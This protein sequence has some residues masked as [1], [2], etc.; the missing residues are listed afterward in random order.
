MKK[1]KDTKV[2]AKNGFTLIELMVVITIISI[3]TIILI[4]PYNF[5]ANISKV[6]VSKDIITQTI[7]QARNSSAWLID[8]NSDSNMN[9]A[10]FITKWNWFID[11][12]WFPYSY[13]WA[14]NQTSSSAKNI[15][16]IRLENWVNITSIKD[17][18]DND[19]TNIVLYFKAPNWELSTYFTP[20]S[21]WS[22]KNITVWFKDATTWILSK[23][24]NVK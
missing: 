7:N 12:V 20:T 4:A 21:T 3:I 23:I 6:R 16:R 18:W 13:S 24:I 2:K 11:M 5:Y 22:L 10:L 19:Q 17:I 8:Y 15:K 1:T 14:I 9:I